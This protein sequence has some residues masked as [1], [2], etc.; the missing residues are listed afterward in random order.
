[1]NKKEPASPF[2]FALVYAG[3]N[4]KEKALE[5]L[6]KAYE[7]KS[8]LVRYLKMEPRYTALMKKSD[9]KNDRQICKGDLF[10]YAIIAFGINF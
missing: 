1:V 3:L 9:W 6:Q 8:G 7:E 5:W 10:H 4:D 2:F